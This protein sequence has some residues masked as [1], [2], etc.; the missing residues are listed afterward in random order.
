MGRSSVSCLSLIG[1]ISLQW[2]S[3]TKPSF[4]KQFAKQDKVSVWRTECVQALNW[5]ESLT[6]A[7]EHDSCKGA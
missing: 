1:L 7:K 6:H 2:F 3:Y 5:E 4:T